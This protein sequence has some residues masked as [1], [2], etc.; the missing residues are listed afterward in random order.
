M[1]SVTM[2][3]GQVIVPVRERWTEGRPGAGSGRAG[4]SSARPGAARVATLGTVKA[5]SALLVPVAAQ[6]DDITSVGPEADPAGAGLDPA[7]VDAIWASVRDWYRLG[8]TPAIQVCLRR[9]GKVVLNRAIGHGWGN[10]PGDGPDTERVA[11]TT[12]SPFCGFSTAKGVSAAVIY[13]LIEQGMFGY[14]DRV[15]DYI[16]E[17]AANGKA[18]ITIG[19]VLAHS[20]GVPFVAPPFRGHEMTFDEDLCLRGLT[21]LKPSYPPGRFRVYHAL[22]SGLILRLLVQRATGKRIRDHLAEHVLNPLGFRWTNLG[23]R[24][25][26]VDAVVPSVKT[27]PPPS[28]IASFVAG[29][30]LGGGFAK[31]AVNRESNRAFLTAELPSGNLVT[32]AAELARFYEILARG[33]ELDGVRV[34]RPE[35]VR[36]MVRPAPRVPG[37]AGRVSRGG[38][39]LGGR[40]SKF[41]R[42]T[43]AHF[44]RSGFTTQYGWADPERG[45]AGGILTSGK[46]SV[47][48][49]RPWQLVAQISAACPPVPP[50]QRVFDL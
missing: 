9:N 31:D 10:A 41:G 47:D 3:F 42:D 36:E 12:E 46:S 20:A 7:D 49:N 5:D 25:E 2:V 16:P 34:L 17:F 40:R 1:I 15:S 28:R 43:T 50:A 27:G 4:T 35:T 18:A 21:A 19:Q 38:Y 23:V 13:L 37:V 22:T 26:E 33:G 11:V 8:G 44:G 30:A 24:P 29:K 6:L 14:D 39:E 45:L 32:T 48:G